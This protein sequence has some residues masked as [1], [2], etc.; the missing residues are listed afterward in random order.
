MI[1]VACYLLRLSRCEGSSEKLWKWG[2]RYG[3]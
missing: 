3:I 1:S 2:L